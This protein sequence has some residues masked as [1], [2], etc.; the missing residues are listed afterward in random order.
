MSATSS[1]LDT[2]IMNAMSEDYALVYKAYCKKF[3]RMTDG[4]KMSLSAG[5]ALKSLGNSLNVDLKTEFDMSTL[6]ELLARLRASDLMRIS[7]S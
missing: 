5:K 2:P 3:K 7:P 4:V 6:T 1:Q